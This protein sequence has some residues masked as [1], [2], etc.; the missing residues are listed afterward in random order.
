MAWSSRSVWR[1]NANTSVMA[2]REFRP[3]DHR[4]IASVVNRPCAL[5]VVKMFRELYGRR[6]TR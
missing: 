6:R 2:R 3:D 4:W 1:D 5:M